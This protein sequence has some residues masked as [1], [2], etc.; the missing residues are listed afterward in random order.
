MSSGHISD[1]SATLSK[2]SGM[3]TDTY[4][5][6]FKLKDVHTSL[7]NALRRTILNGIPIVSFNDFYENNPE[8]NKIRIHKNISALHNEFVS[9]RLSLI[10]ICMYKNDSLKVQVDYS[11]HRFK[12]SFK[13]EDTVPI[14]QL[15]V[16]ND[17]ETRARL[18]S[19]T[20]ADHTI[21]VTTNHITI[22]DSEQFNDVREFFI[23]D[24]ITGD[25]VLIHK[26]KPISSSDDS[27]EFE[28]LDVDLRPDINTALENA[29]YCPVG[30]VSYEFE[31]EHKIIEGQ[32][33]EYI[34]HLQS[35][36]LVDGL[37][38]FDKQDIEHFRGSYNVL[39]AERHYLKNEQGEA[40]SVIFCV[41]SV[42][43][44]QS[45]QIVYDAICI[46]ELMTNVLLNSFTWSDKRSKYVVD[47]DKVETKKNTKSGVIEVTIFNETHTLGNLI[48]GHLKKAFIL[49]DD[50]N[51]YLSFASYKQPHPLKNDIVIM[52]GLIEGKDY[53][54]LFHKFG[55]SNPE[56]EIDKAYQLIMISCNIYLAMIKRIKAE[57][58]NVS[59]ISQPSFEV[60]EGND[61]LTKSVY[62]VSDKL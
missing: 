55:L 34:K 13:D 54:S 46:L 9:H 38:E 50:S 56:S 53:G 3:E 22:Q 57:W 10:P 51:K 17:A 24:Y 7:A 5:V 41:E 20:N 19:S 42:G 28:E 23:P 26:L 27:Q 40:S 14:F 62:D 15:K 12:Y 35:Q 44:L 4:K 18:A 16:R 39:D 30:T 11:D 43:N 1:Y 2:V 58:T 60:V 59:L 21:D 6:D 49:G 45:H 29:R 36:R 33:N 37:G 61:Y 25:Y 52:L 32:F 8:D 47:A 31:K 48:A